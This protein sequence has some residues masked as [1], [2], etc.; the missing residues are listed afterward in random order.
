MAFGT[1]DRNLQWPAQR[2]A[3]DYVGGRPEDIALVDSTAEGLALIYHGLS[4][5]SGDEILATTH[6]HFV[7]QSQSASRRR[8]SVLPGGG[9]RCPIAQK[10]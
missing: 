4:L 1:R 7:H 10:R 3:A 5:K 2:A 8:N 9:C 6:D